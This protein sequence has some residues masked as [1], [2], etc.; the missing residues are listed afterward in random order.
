MEEPGHCLSR[1]LEE[2]NLHHVSGFCEDATGA[3]G[4]VLLIPEFTNKHLLNKL[5]V[6][7]EADLDVWLSSLLWDFISE[8]HKEKDDPFSQR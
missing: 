8:S 5:I 3:E 6:S 1:K 7:K 2:S 4:S